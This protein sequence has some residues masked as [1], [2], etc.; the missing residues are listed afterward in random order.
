MPVTIIS[1]LTNKQSQSDSSLYFNPSKLESQFNQSKSSFSDWL[2][3]IIVSF[4][5]DSYSEPFLK[6]IDALAYWIYEALMKESLFDTVGQRLVNQ[7]LRLVRVLCTGSHR[8]FL[9]N[10]SAKL[11]IEHVRDVEFLMVN[12]SD[13]IDNQFMKDYFHT[14]QYAFSVKKFLK[15]YN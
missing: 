3:S 7:Y 12:R 4:K 11:Q 10:P 9:N 14:L 13:V 15:E 2:E 6:D 5:G 8:E 1:L